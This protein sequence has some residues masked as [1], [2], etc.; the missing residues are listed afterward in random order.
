MDLLKFLL[1]PI[2]S[3]IVHPNGAQQST[4][5]SETYILTSVEQLGVSGGLGS[6][7]PPKPGIAGKLLGFYFLNVFLLNIV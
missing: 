5:I 1:T 6:S 2:L 4:D 7:F 3:L